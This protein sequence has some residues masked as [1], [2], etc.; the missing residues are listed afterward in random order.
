MLTLYAIT[1]LILIIYGYLF[2]VFLKVAK[3]HYTPDL[4]Q[5]FMV[6]YDTS[7]TRAATVK[8]PI[9][10]EVAIRELSNSKDQNSLNQK[11]MFTDSTTQNNLMTKPLSLS[12]EVQQNVQQLI[13]G[14]SLDHSNSTPKEVSITDNLEKEA[15]RK[16]PVKMSFIADAA[17][18]KENEFLFDK[19]LLQLVQLHDKAKK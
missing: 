19:D 3:G 12:T 4:K 5:D 2:R 7:S 6:Q 11:T 14:T 13:A 10:K 17:I 9:G 1:L 16:Q 18:V 8:A 15:S